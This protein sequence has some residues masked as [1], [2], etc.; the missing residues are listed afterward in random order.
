LQILSNRLSHARNNE[1]AARLT[2]AV[3]QQRGK[4]NDVNTMEES[5]YER[6]SAADAARIENLSLRDKITYSTVNIE[7]YQ[8]A[9]IKR[10]VLVNNKNL[11]MYAP[12]LLQKI[13]HSLN[14]G[15]SILEAVLLFLVKFWPLA[16][17]GMIAFFAV[18]KFGK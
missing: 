11:G 6:Q 2:Q 8:Q 5:I 3:A 7:L 9:G 17:F 10:S 18:K 12:S 13:G 1:S 16:I 4:L 15:W 14:F